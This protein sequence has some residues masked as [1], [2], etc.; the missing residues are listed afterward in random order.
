MGDYDYGEFCRKL[1]RDAGELARWRL[2]MLEGSRTDVGLQGD[3]RYMAGR[4]PLFWMLGFIWTYDPRLKAPVVP[5]AMYSF[6]ERMFRELMEGIGSRD[7]L[8]DKCRDIGA[9]WLNMGAI[10]HKWMYIPRVTFLVASAKED[11]VDRSKDPD[12]LFWKVDFMLDHMPPWL[13]PTYERKQLNFFNPVMN[14]TID[15]TSTTGDLSRGGRRTAILLDEFASVEQGHAVLAAAKHATNSRVMNST[16]RGTNTAFYVMSKNEAIKKI[17]VDWWEH[18]LWS[19]GLYRSVPRSRDSATGLVGYELQIMDAGYE[20]SDDYQFICDGKMRSPWY[21]D[22]CRR[23]MHPSEIAREIDRNPQGSDSQFFDLNSLRQQRD[24][25]VRPPICYGELEYNADSAEPSYF[26]VGST[27]RFMLW[28]I[29]GELGKFSSDRQ[30]VLSADI[31]TGT[32]ASNSA[33]MI[34]DRKTGEKIGEFVSSHIDPNE[35]GKMAVS[36]ARWLNNAFLIWEAN[37][38]GR[39]F[40]KMVLDAGYRNIYWRKEEQTLTKK[41]SDFPGFYSSRPTKIVLL[42]EYRRALIDG[43]FQQVSESSIAEAEEYVFSADGDIRHAKSANFVDP[44][45]A[46]DNHGDRVIADALLY[47]ALKG[48]A[49]GEKPVATEVPENSIAGRRERARRRAMAQTYW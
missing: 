33:L 39:I 16:H 19:K 13:R 22:Q 29:P 8:I 23:A 41:Q 28:V 11:L 38:P 34:G 47:M 17:E 2:R 5:F 32:G 46:R 14:T 10:V 27:G 31:A 26:D 43:K 36:M 3:L 45:G 18:P 15:G 1:P 37:G 30:Y 20:F 44:S 48:D 49:K 12:C 40:G 42:G 21:D 24:S 7:L 9:S 35:F 4:D 25:H 6:Q